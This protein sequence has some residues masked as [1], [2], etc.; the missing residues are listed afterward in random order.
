MTFHDLVSMA[1]RL[2]NEDRIAVATLVWPEIGRCWSIPGPPV[3]PQLFRAEL[4]RRVAD[5]DA[6]RSRTVTLEEFKRSMDAHL[7]DHRA[8]DS[9][10]IPPGHTLGDPP[11][12]DEF[13]AVVAR[14]VAEDRRHFALGV[15]PDEAY[16]EARYGPFRTV[17]EVD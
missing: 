3:D 16:W 14:M 8:R 17:E 1:R 5:V 12:R 11:S 4:G 9:R 10:R 15:W 2:P 6:G 13:V 7:A